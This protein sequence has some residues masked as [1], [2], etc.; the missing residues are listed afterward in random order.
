MA[1]YYFNDEIGDWE[2]C[3]RPYVKYGNIWTAGRNAY[4]KQG[5]IWQRAYAYDTTPPDPPL[6]DLIL[7]EVYGQVD[8]SRRVTSRWIRVGVRTPAAAHDPDLAMIRVL[9][10]YGGQAPTTPFGGTYTSQ[11]DASYPG[12]PWSDWKYGPGFPHQ[13][14]SKLIYKQWPRNATEGTVLKGDTNYHFGAWAVD[15]NGNWSQA[16]QTHLNI[17]KGGVDQPQVHVKEAAFQP[18]ATGSWKKNQY[19]AG[20]LIQQKSPR[21]MGLW[22]YGRQFT[23]NLNSKS[24]ISS[25]QIYIYRGSDNGVAN[26]NIYLFWTTYK[27]PSD[28]PPVG[29]SIVRNQTQKLGQLAKGQGK[30]FEVPGQMRD[31]MKNGNLKGLGLDWKDPDKADANPND[32]SLV[33]STAAIARCGEVHMVWEQET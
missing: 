19:E 1:L 24:K 2:L 15:K 25:C 17:P 33:A 5:G 3:Q 32:Y 13:D 9:T 29:G 14:S 26:A 23:D 27:S 11:P 30:W 16:T 31:D 18:N 12:E 22:F 10:D 20:H 21:S 7:H 28:L 8:G 4:I 6:V